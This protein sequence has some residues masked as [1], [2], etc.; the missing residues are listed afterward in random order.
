MLLNQS[1]TR[2]SSHDL[3]MS[4]EHMREGQSAYL[5][6]SVASC[7]SENSDSVGLANTVEAVAATSW[8]GR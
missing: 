4:V 6:E 3:D 2:D 1:P 7:G 5:T 8:G